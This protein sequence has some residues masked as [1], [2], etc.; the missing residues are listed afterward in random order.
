MVDQEIFSRYVQGCLS[1]LHDLAFLETHPLGKL[2]LEADTQQRGEALRAVLLDAIGRLEPIGLIQAPT[3]PEWR[4]YRYLRLHYEEGLSLHE[5]ARQLGISPR[6][7]SRD[8]QEA[9]QTLASVLWARHVRLREGS[10]GDEDGRLPAA[11]AEPSGSDWQPALDEELIHLAMVPAGGQTGPVELKE[12]AQG[13]LAT[14]ARFA[15]ERGVSLE[16]ALSDTVSP[17]MV[18]RTVLRHALFNLLSCAIEL[19]GNSRIV[20][21]NADTSRG[22]ELRL[23]VRR[24]QGRPPGKSRRTSDAAR[25]EALLLA[26]R[27]LLETQG[28]TAELR[29]RPDGN[30][31]IDVVLLPVQMVNVLV[32]DD[33]PDVVGLFRRYLRQTSYRL[34]QA[35]TAET[36]LKLAVELK[37]DIITLDL[38]MPSQD[39]WEILQ[40]LRGSEATRDIPIVVCSVLPENGVALSLGVAGFVGKPVTRASLLA[41]LER[42]LRKPRPGARPS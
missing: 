30:L 36:A 33:N 14:I 15:E 16:L 12:T 4:R 40:Q 8:Q 25:G 21:S 28:G 31:T 1:H 24:R 10:R 6:Q 37:P 39:G 9:V 13:V 18:S 19:E 20:I 27:R 35:G 42:C 26:G 41:A 5:A 22:V 17:V 11:T 7:A 23:D 29:R 34:I 2:V 32:V 3:S 38:M